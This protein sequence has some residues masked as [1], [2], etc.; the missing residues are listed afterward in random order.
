VKRLKFVKLQL[1]QT[2][3]V[4]INSEKGCGDSVYCF[5]IEIW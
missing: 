2:A 1:L 4:I 3:G 5:Q